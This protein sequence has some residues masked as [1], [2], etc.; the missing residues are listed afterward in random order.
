MPRWSS[1]PLPAQRS[2][3]PEQYLSAMP[4]SDSYRTYVLEQLGRAVSNIRH[5]AM[6]GGIGIYSNDFFFA[7]IDD[8]KVYFKVDDSNRPDYEARKLGPFMPFGEGG[9]VMQYYEIA[10]ETLEDIDQLREWAEKAIDVARSRRKPAK[11]PAKRR[12]K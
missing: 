3:A 6:F 8:D 5:K 11:T 4:V 12:R 2:K 10:E 9:E 7:L 1:G